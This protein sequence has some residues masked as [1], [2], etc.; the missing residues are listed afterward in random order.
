M[1]VH[2]VLSKELA[3]LHLIQ[4]TTIRVTLGTHQTVN[5]LG[6]MCYAKPERAG[7]LVI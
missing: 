5:T 6:K 1:F 7:S 4:V 2:L 3:L